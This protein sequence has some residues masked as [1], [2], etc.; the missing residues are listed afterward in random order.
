MIIILDSNVVMSAL[1]KNSQTRQI[2]FHSGYKF[3]HPKVALRNLEKYKEEI[4]KKTGMSEEEYEKLLKTLFENI[5]LVDEADF[6]DKLEEAKMIMASIDIED[7]PF[8][9]L[10]LSMQNDGI[11]SDDNHFQKQ[12]KIKIWRTGEVM[13]KLM[14]Q[15]RDALS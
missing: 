12:N 9:A 13:K 6:L 3:Y 1:I 8:I 4:M 14:D 5:I 7:V 10:A 11:W 2:I 15:F